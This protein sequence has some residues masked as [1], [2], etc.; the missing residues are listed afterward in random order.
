MVWLGKLSYSLYLWHWPVLALLRYYTGSQELDL[1][2]SL[3]FIGITLL[4]TTLSYFAVETPMRAHRIRFK[5]VLGYI[6][7]AG[8]A[9]VTGPVMASINHVLSPAP[10]PIEYQRYADVATICHGQIV[11]TCLKGDLNSDKEVLVLGDSHAAMLNLFFDEL[12]KDIGFKARII[13]ASSCVTIPGFDYQ[14]IPEWAHKPCLAQIEQA[15]QYLPSAQIVFLAASWTWQLT[16]GEFQPTLEAFLSTQVQAGARV[17]LMEQEPLLS[18][19]PMRAQRFKALGLKSS[20][21]IDPVYQLTN[22]SLQSIATRNSGTTSL[23]FEATGFFANAPFADDFLIYL[24]EH[25]LNEVGAKR[26]AA[27]RSAFEKI[28]N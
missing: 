6:L 19:S 5:Q 21:N 20:I 18:R 22:A 13:T 17:Y 23:G 7:L 1:P 24:D 16:S 3:F 14:R 15:Q 26:Y 10:L 8:S 27:A 11:G 2:F 4:L 12:G 25:H 28:M 9:L